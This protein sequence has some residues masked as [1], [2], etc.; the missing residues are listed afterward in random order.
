L[1]GYVNGG[2]A[3][4]TKSEFSVFVNGRLA[5]LAK[6]EVLKVPACGATVRQIKRGT[7]KGFAN[8][9]HARLTKREML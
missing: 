1:L 5:Q 6:L 4:K 9:N 2:F 8:G 3:H 7:L